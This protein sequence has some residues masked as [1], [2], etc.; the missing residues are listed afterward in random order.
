M[1][2]TQTRRNRIGLRE[3]GAWALANLLGWATG[4]WLGLSLA[5]GTAERLEPML[6]TLGAMTLGWLVGG[7]VSGALVGPLQAAVL[8]ERGVAAAPWAAATALGLG[9]GFAAVIPA[10]IFFDPQDTEPLTIALMVLAGLGPGVAQWL[11]L[12]RVLPGAGWWIPASAVAVALLF[13]CGVFL[14]G[15]GR[16]WLAAGAG[17]LAYATATGVALAALLGRAGR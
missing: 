4:L 16:E 17:G 10:L 11:V 9:I 6:G 7:L 1:I 13:L 2:A 15:E 3:L 14:G 5:W 8:R 12:R